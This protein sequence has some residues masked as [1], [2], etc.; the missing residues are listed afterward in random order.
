MSKREPTWQVEALEVVRALRAGG[1]VLTST[2]T[3]WG[4]ACD[5]TQPEAVARMAALKGRPAEK[6][7]IALVADD[8]LFARLLPDLPESGWELMEASDRPVTV[9]GQAGPRHGLAPGMVRQDGS[10]G[11]RRVD[12]PYLAFILR[13]VNRP[14][15]STSAN[16]SGKESDGTFRSVPDAIVEAVDAVG[17]FRQEGAGGQPSWLVQFDAEGRFKVLRP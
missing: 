6:S 15:A 9:V 17:V 7:F 12:D 3:V 2:D 1:V 8:G 10:L 13:G 4:L 11:V 16:L 5:A 14:L